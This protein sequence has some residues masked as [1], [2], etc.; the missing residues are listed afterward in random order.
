MKGKTKFFSR[1]SDLHK[2]N[3]THPFDCSARLK[4][5]WIPNQF[6]PKIEDFD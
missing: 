6:A 1:I 5:E 2:E 4:T 3:I